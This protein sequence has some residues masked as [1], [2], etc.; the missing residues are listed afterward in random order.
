MKTQ[1]MGIEIEFYGITRKKAIGVVAGVVGGNPVYVGHPHSRWSVRSSD[2][3]EWHVEDDSSI[4]A[5]NSEER[6]EFVSPILTY[7]DMDRVQEIVRA[8]RAAGAKSDPA[9]QCGIHVHVGVNKHNPLTLRNLVNI[10]ASKEELI[11]QSLDVDQR[12]VGYCKKMS[13]DFLTMVNAVRPTTLQQMADLWYAKYGNA[14]RDSHYHQSRY[15]GLNLH[16]VFEK[17]HTVEFRLFNGC[18]HAG[19]IRSYLVFCLAVSHQAIKQ[20]SASPSRTSTDNQKYT[21]RCWLLRLGLIGEEFKN[22][23]TH[24]MENLSGDCAWR[25][26]RRLA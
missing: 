8:L 6:C 12:R 26:A 13:E 20:K 3:R 19:K 18:L 21:F 7:Q 14:S 25:D 2:G 16:S 23:R 5:N 4:K 10:M 22:V 24:L 11:Y 1:T 9:H 15:H 17:G